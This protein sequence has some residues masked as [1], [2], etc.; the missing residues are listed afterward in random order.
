MRDAHTL[1]PPPSEIGEG[2]QSAQNLKT[3]TDTV[4]AGGKALKELAD[5]RK[6]QSCA[7]TITG[8]SSIS[9]PTA[10]N[11]SLSGKRAEGA[12]AYLKRPAWT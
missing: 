6:D 8:Y 12:A 11:K 4:P 1:L 3:R 9:G 7:I 10:F 2:E 5:K